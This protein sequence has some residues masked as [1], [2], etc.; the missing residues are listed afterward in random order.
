MRPVAWFRSIAVALIALGAL[1]PPA[2]SAQARYYWKSLS[3]ANV[4]PVIFESLSSNSNPADPAHI[5]VPGSD[6]SGTIGLAGYGRTFSL[7]DR[8]AMAAL[9]VPLGRVSGEVTALGVTA[10]QSASGFGDPMV[11]M[12]VNVVGP[13]AQNTLADVVR[14]EP[15]FSLDVLADLA[16]PIGQYNSSQALNLGQHRW[17]GRV[18]LPVVWQLGPWVPGERTTI[19]A[20]PA[21]WWFTPNNDY[22]EGKKLTTDVLFQLDAHVTRD[23]TAGLWVS[24]DALWYLGGAAAID[25]VAG[26]KL[27]NFGVGA[28]A[29]YQITENL[30]LTA[31]YMKLVSS[32][33]PNSLQ[34]DRFSFALLYGWHSLV[35][36]ARRLEANEK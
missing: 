9:I 22:L 15:G 8:A 24:L 33:S 6:F 16:F 5:V 17:Y 31:S 29:G 30:S 10:F 1:L 28:T 7:F 21:M 27:N 13:R 26:E 20:L 2:A 35:E 4:V 32:G 3:N 11:E 25:G 14:Y 18:G 23:L 19:E 34:M 12:V 36:G